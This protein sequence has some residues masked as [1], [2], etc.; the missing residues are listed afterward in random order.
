VFRDDAAIDGRKHVANDVRAFHAQRG[1]QEMVRRHNSFL[2][3]KSF[4]QACGFW[5]LLYVVCAAIVGVIAGRISI[6]AAIPGAIVGG[7]LLCTAIACLAGVREKVSKVNAIRRS[8]RGDQIR[9]GEIIAA[10]GRITPLHET[11]TSPFGRVAC[12]AYKYRIEVRSL[13]KLPWEY[14]GAALAPSM[15]QASRG[16]MKLLALPKLEVPEKE[17]RGVD[18]AQFVASTEF[19]I[20]IPMQPIDTRSPR[21]RYDHRRL[22]PDPLDHAI[23]YEKVVTPGQEV[24]VLGVYSAVEGGLTQEPD[25]V[26]PTLTLMNGDASAIQ[27]DLVSRALGNLIAAIVS[28]GLLL[29]SLAALYIISNR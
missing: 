28:V 27:R 23:V 6:L 3:V 10:A 17:C 1:V 12:V 26:I 14:E 15:I 7:G 11:L 24:C 18:A 19:E 25:V 16:S 4:K 8:L 21:V 5:T 29:A 13:R 2:M 9:D 22:K 20:Q